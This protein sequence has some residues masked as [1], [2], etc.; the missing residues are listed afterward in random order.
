MLKDP[1]QIFY[2][3]YKFDKSEIKEV[4]FGK[5]YTAI[6]LKTGN[7]GLSANLNDIKQSSFSY[8]NTLDLLNPDHRLIL[9]AYYNAKFNYKSKGQLNKDLFDEI[10][11]KSYRNIVM[12]G[13]SKP[14]LNKLDSKEQD[15]Y[16]FD[17]SKND[18]IIVDQSLQKKYLFE[19]ECVILTATTIVNNT[20]MEIVSNS[21][22][23]CDLFLVGPSTPM[24][25][26]MFKYRNVKALFGTIFKKND[27]EVINIIKKGEGTRIFKHL[28]KKVALIK[29]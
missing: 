22:S 8:N 21:G 3:R 23:S 26:E 20:F 4:I 12:I 2:D 27:T 17:N 19:A 1:L 25:E 6:I 18:N 7:I 13:Y 11:F 28:G 10:N 16:I 14:M 24:S 5:I 29:N 15:I 9:N